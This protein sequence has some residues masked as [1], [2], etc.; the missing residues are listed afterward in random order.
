MVDKKDK[1]ILIPLLFSLVFVCLL[2]M[3]SCVCPLFSF[4]EKKTGVEVSTAAS[5]DTNF[6]DDELVYPGSSLGLEV[7]GK[8]EDIIDAALD[9]GIQVTEQEMM[10]VGAATEDIK[11]EEI[12]ALI[13]YSSDDFHEIDSYYS[14]LKEKG[15]AVTTYDSGSLQDQG[16]GSVIYFFSREDYEQPLLL[17]IS[18]G[19]VFLVFIDY[20]WDSL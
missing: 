18:G 8:I 14:S 19:R 10:L 15:W 13:Y 7:T 20:D 4:I 11:E 3:T 17:N 6:L 5:A 2:L 16:Q 12:S 9:F 1:L